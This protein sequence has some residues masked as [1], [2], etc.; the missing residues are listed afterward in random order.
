M[1]P[2]D[3]S[4]L[5]VLRTYHLVVLPPQAALGQSSLAAR[6]DMVEG[7]QESFL[8]ATDLL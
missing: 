4:V 1:I 3:S 2:Q 8:K 5:R 6:Q 7:H